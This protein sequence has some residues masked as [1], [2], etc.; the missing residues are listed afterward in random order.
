[1]I[2]HQTKNVLT[3]VSLADLYVEKM[4]YAAI[5][6]ISRSYRPTVPVSYISH[7]LGF[8][9]GLPTAETI[10]VKEADGV[11]ECA[12]WLKAHGGCLVTENSAE[13]L[14]DAKVCY[15]HMLTYFRVWPII[16][17]ISGVTFHALLLKAYFT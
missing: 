7:V 9:N 5:K 11:E 13:I 12:E 1:M 2:S 15:L 14:F 4:R 10:D 3:F 17:S 6:C 16:R 8:S